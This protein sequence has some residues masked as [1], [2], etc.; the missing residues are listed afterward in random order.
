MNH[1]KAAAHKYIL[2]MAVLLSGLLASGARAELTP[3][4]GDEMDEVTG[5]NGIAFEIDVRINNS[6]AIGTLD[7]TMCPST[8]R[9]QCRLANKF[10]NRNHCYSAGN[11][12]EWL[13]WKGF[14]GRLYFPKL[15]VDA[16]T[17]SA[18]PTPYA[19]T[20]RLRSGTGVLVSPY[21]Q[22]NLMVRM[23]AAAQVYNFAIR[24]MSFEYGSGLTGSCAAGCGFQSD[25]TDSNS[26]IGLNINSTVSGQPAT[27]RFDG[28][29]QW[30]GF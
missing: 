23:P 24:G 18:S 25:P 11:C 20:S 4:S 28:Q 21:N 3:M 26:F 19:D 10:A 5:Q 12:G 8:N 29:M 2:A 13:V 6:D 7:A 14:S 9:V 16:T 30:W 22:L 15:W 17:T 1:R 27:I